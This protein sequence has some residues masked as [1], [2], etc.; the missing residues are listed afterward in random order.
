MKV[1]LTQDVYNLGRAGDVKN[2]A[3]GYGR[4]Y[5]LPRGL[6]ILATPVALKR[7]ERIKQVAV[8]KR[9]REKADVDSLAQMIGGVALT[10]NVRAGEKGKLF[11]S[12]TATHI[13]DAIS[14]KIGIEF[15]K[16]KVALREPI[17]DVGTFTVPV[18]L[19]AEVAPAVTVVVQPEGAAVPEQPAQA[20][21]TDAPSEVASEAVKAAEADG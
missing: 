7:A 19:S 17:R 18:R 6:A 13:A 2:V 9:A 4:N 12:I 20:A 5:L 14:K 1:L 21:P 8:E 10:F 11:G 16:R 15:D 3:D